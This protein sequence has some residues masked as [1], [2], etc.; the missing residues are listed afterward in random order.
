LIDD[1][2]Q[3]FLLR[4][5]LALR[6]TTKQST[7]IIS[8]ATTNIHTEQANDTANLSTRPSK[9]TTT[10]D[11]VKTC[12]DKLIFHYIH[13]KRFHS[14]KRDMHKLYIDHFGNPLAMNIRLIVGNRNR[15]SLSHELIRKRPKKALLQNRQIKSMYIENAH[16]SSS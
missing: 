2:K 3:Y 7:R 4:N 12:E 15:R 6:P 13:E 1:E 11:K 14:F 8:N 9:T 5:K 16:R 10:T